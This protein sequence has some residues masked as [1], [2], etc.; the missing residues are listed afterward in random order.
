MEATLPKATNPEHEL[1][2]NPLILNPKGV[3]TLLEFMEEALLPQQ[4]NRPAGLGL[5]V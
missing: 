4:E 5:R 2:P 1:N 3:K